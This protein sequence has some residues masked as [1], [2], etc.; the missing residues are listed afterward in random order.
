VEPDRRELELARSAGRLAA[1]GLAV[2]AAVAILALVAAYASASFVALGVGAHLLAGALAWGAGLALLARRGGQLARTTEDERLAAAAESEGRKPLFVRQEKTAL[3]QTESRLAGGLGVLLALVEAG[4]AA[5]LVLAGRAHAEVAPVH[6]LAVA[7]VLASSSFVLLLL[8][9]FTGARGAEPRETGGLVRGNADEAAFS[10]TA[11]GG[12]RAASGAF[13]ALASAVVLATENLA[14]TLGLDALG[15]VFA[16]VEGLLAFE[17]LVALVLELY[18]PRRKGELPRPGYESRLLALLAE[19]SGVARSLARAVD[20]QFGFQLSETWAYGLVER[21]IAPLIIFIALSFWVLSAFVLVPQGEVALHERLGER[22][23]ILEPGLHLKAP[24]PIDRV[25]PVALDRVRTVHLGVEEAE[26][27]EGAVSRKRAALWTKAHAKD[28]F[29]V[30]VPR[31]GSEGTDL[32]AA[33]ADVRFVVT[34]AEEW[35]LDASQPEALLKALGEREL[36]RLGCSRDLDSLLGPGRGAAAIELAAEIQK[37]AQAHKL[38]VK[39]LDVG[40]EDFH[41]PVEVAPSFHLETG[42]L[43]E[44]DALCQK[45]RGDAAGARPSGESDAS[46]IRARAVTDAAQK[47]R[48]ARASAEAFHAALCLDRAGPH[49]FRDLL[50]LG[51]LEEA[52]ARGGRRV[53][54]PRRVQAE[55]DL[56]DKLNTNLLPPEEK[57]PGPGAQSPHGPESGGAGAEPPNR[58]GEK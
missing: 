45:A 38:G 57:P 25:E 29:L 17:L 18:R 15:F 39:I 12:R 42:A 32:L 11:A 44:R 5:F 26:E 27:E 58:A 7:A 48:L 14:P 30:L 34:N 56:S 24:W 47:V 1:A 9:K 51:V 41:P 35:A 28:E 16:G 8:A 31:Q 10:L 2:Q 21:G 55:L 20:Y 53:V 54:V 43:E 36:A 33:G 49:V 22:I 13:F 3:A 37:S 6:L 19:P 50:R 46:G 40:L 23:A 4:L 52:L